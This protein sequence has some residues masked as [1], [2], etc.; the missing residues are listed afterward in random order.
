MSVIRFPVPTTTRLDTILFGRTYEYRGDRE[1][2]EKYGEYNTRK[3]K[4]S[5]QEKENTNNT[6]I[7]LYVNQ[8]FSERNEKKKRKGENKKGR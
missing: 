7:V 5:T 4:R 3:K 2:G 1:N 8:F 6:F